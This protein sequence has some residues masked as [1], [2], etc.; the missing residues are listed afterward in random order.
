MASATADPA[1]GIRLSLAGGTA[2][3][4]GTDTIEI[5]YDG[6]WRITRGDQ[7][8]SG[9]CTIDQRLPYASPAEFLRGLLAPQ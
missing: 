1:V 3:T 4:L 9:T 2:D 8:V 7:L 6:A 5:D